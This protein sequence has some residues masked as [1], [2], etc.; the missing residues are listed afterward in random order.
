MFISRRIDESKRKSYTTSQTTAGADEKITKNVNPESWTSVGANEEILI[1]G[2]EDWHSR[3]D[4][5][6]YVS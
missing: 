2:E 5:N 3:Y 1:V 4:P 6:L